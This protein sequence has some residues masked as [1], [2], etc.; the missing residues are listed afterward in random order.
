MRDDRLG[1]I[2]LAKRLISR[3]QLES[4][5]AEQRRHPERLLGNLLIQQGILSHAELVRIIVSEQHLPM[6]RAVLDRRKQANQPLDAHGV[7]LLRVPPEEAASLA[8]AEG[9]FPSPTP[10]PRLE[11]FSMTSETEKELTAD[12]FIAIEADKLDEARQIIT[13]GLT[14]LPDSL[15]MRYLTAW[16]QSMDK[17]IDKSLLILDQHF[18]TSSDNAS[19][20]WLMAWNLQ[21]LNRHKEAA[22][23]LQRM[24]RRRNPLQGWYFALAYSLDE[25]RFW[26]KARQVYT[27]FIRITQGESQYTWYARQ[28]LRI[29]I[30]HLEKTEP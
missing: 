7:P 16:L 23:L 2:L 29:I 6:A 1:D 15:P 10:L 5:L 13:Q 4:A 9:A 14:I 25:L 20:L 3:S 24:L 22:D 11:D 30:E 27:Y 19:A 17:R 12:A 26:K 8:M 18:G 28:R 21:K